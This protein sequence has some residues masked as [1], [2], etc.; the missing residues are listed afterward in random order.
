M[1]LSDYFFTRLLT[2]SRE[3]FTNSLATCVKFDSCESFEKKSYIIFSFNCRGKVHGAPWTG[4]KVI[5]KWKKKVED[6]QTQSPL[7]PSLTYFNFASMFHW[8]SLCNDDSRFQCSCCSTTGNCCSIFYQDE[9]TAV[10]QIQGGQESMQRTPLSQPH[11]YVKGI[12]YDFEEIDTS[13]LK[14]FI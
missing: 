14:T 3:A 1:N 11:V 4:P 13:S 10:W 7:P 8:V 9:K 2:L 5:L 6:Y 12:L